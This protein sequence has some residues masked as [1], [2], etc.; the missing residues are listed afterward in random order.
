MKKKNVE[1]KLAD[2]IQAFRERKEL[3]VKDISELLSCNRQSVYNYIDRLGERGFE[4]ERKTQNRA[5]YFTLISNG[6]TTSQVPYIPLTDKILRKCNVVQN[7][8]TASA[9][10]K[11]LEEPLSFCLFRQTGGG[12]NLHWFQA[13]Y[14]HRI[15]C[16]SQP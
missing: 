16:I 2:L 14:R 15:L 8:Q 11:A 9:T 7:L 1:E 4:L 6:T 10:P 5:V 12:R 3:S 13:A